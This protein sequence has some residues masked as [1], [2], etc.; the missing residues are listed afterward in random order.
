MPV[1]LSCFV[2]RYF[3]KH[4]LVLS[5]YCSEGPLAQNTKHKAIG[6]F[7]HTF[8]SPLSHFTT[9]LSTD[10][11][12]FPLLFLCPPVGCLGCGVWVTEAAPDPLLGS[13]QVWGAG[14]KPIDPTPHAGHPGPNRP[15]IAQSAADLDPISCILGCAV[16]ITIRRALFSN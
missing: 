1:S 2:A 5:S 14:T 10:M 8:H 4:L 12:H 16:R 15:K 6:L 9:L 11:P 7:T 3:F 13:M